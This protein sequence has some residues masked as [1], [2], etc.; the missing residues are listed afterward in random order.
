MAVTAAGIGLTSVYSIERDLRMA[1][2]E[3][4]ELAGYTFRFEGTEPVRGPNY[5]GERGLIA[6]TRGDG[7]VA[8][9]HPE[10]R[11]YLARSSQMMTEAAI[12]AS[13]MRD[14]YVALGEP[15]GDDGAWAVRLH[16]KP[17]VRWIWL[18]AL[19]MA[20]GAGLAAADRR[21]RLGER[22]VRAAPTEAAVA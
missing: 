13:L 3:S 7:E 12:D 20:A 22:S 1:P 4:A 5:V 15:L 2:G 18:G 16:F 9:L 10:K 21:Y 6:V 14:L 11:R 19:F 17:F 8:L